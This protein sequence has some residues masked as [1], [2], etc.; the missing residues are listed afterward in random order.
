[1][2]LRYTS[3]DFLNICS[4]QVREMY[5]HWA[6]LRGER[7]LPHRDDLDPARITRYLPGI[8]LVDVIW[9]PPLDFVYRLV[10]TREAE[11]RGADP[12]GQRV[13]DAFFAASVADAI[14]NYTYVATE[15]A[16]LYDCE[17]V[18]KPGNR[19]MSD[20]C[21]FLPFTRDGERVG[22]I[23]V[24]SHYEDLWSRPPA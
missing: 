1:M 21:L 14:A 13:A 15:R 18:S 11:S 24:Y 6:A 5:E 8:M 12:T 10:G 22:Q 4:R 9:G 7:A 2:T 17:R 20:E 23:L 16:V 19:Y 3:L